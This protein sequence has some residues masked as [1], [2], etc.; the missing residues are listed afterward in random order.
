[1]ANQISQIIKMSPA[2]LQRLIDTRPSYAHS[3]FLSQIRFELTR[4][5]SRY[6]ARHENVPV[7][8]NL[9]FNLPAGAMHRELT[10]YMPQLV[11]GARRRATAAPRR[12]RVSLRLV[13]QISIWML[14]PIDDL[15]QLHVNLVR[16]Q[17]VNFHRRPK[18]KRH[19]LGNLRHRNDAVRVADGRTRHFELLI[20]LLFKR[21]VDHFAS[22]SANRDFIADEGHSAHIDL[23]P[24]R[25]I[26]QNL[27]SHLPAERLESELSAFDVSF[28]EEILGKNPDAVAALFRLAAIG[29]Q[30]L[31]RDLPA[32]K[33]RPIQE[34][35]PIQFRSFGGRFA[36]YSPPSN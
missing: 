32:V 30:N 7:R 3:Q 4:H 15:Q 8:F 36:G 16:K 35:R 10:V 2:F 6:A 20:S 17:R 19:L 9:N 23:D 28:I 18:F 12:Q 14:P 13:S 25:L 34:S 5:H 27:D 31:Q 22:L 21:F 26:V 33:E 1:M 29:I 24:P 11:C